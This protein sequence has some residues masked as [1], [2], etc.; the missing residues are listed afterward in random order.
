MRYLVIL[1]VIIAASAAVWAGYLNMAA[2]WEEDP[3][4][5]GDMPGMSSN[6]A[7]AMI[8]AQ[9][10]AM[11]D[12]IAGKVLY[13]QSCAACHGTNLEGQ[14]NWQSA[15][16]SGRVPAPPHDRTGHTWHHADSLLFN[17][18]KLG[19]KEALAREGVDFNSGMPA[20]GDQYSDQQIRDILA[21]IKST[22]PDRERQAQAQRTEAERLME[23][24][25]Q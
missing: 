6:E 7:D 2:V 17:Y 5:M 19:G 20:F 15:D 13:L 24:E 4:G 22:W 8:P 9:M 16:A 10:A 25:N 18:T 23:E 14:P 21:Y 3:T 11:D 1:G 12:P